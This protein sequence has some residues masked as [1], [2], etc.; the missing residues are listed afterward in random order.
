VTAPPVSSSPRRRGQRRRR[1]PGYAAAAV[2]VLV[3]AA[4]VLIWAPWRPAP[5]LR[6]TGLKAGTATTGSVMFHWSDP[7]SGPPPDRY[8]ILSS[9]K[10]VGTVAGTVTSYRAS[11]LAPATAY[12][13]RVAALRG[14]KR[15]AL[16]AVLTVNTTAPPVSAARWQGHWSVNIKIVKGAEALRGK[17]AKGWVESWRASPQCPAG[18]CTV[19][20]TGD[21]NRHPIKAT[22]T[23]AGAVYTGKTTADIF[24]CGKPADSVP[25]R[26]TLT[27]QVTLGAGQPS[28]HAWVASAWRGH[29]V[30]DSPYTS[31]STFYCNAF[32]LTTSLSGSF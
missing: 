6:P 20:L 16:S 27:I 29:M 32:T 31:T 17:G 24:K 19:Q 30:I 18:P 10:V 1:W 7:A 11:G 15:S 2:V 12:Q 14:G 8:Q 28:G 23:R 5:L 13:Y 21:L 9:G 22:L 25:I 4:G 3:I 26:S